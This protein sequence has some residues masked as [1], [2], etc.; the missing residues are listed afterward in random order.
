MKENGHQAPLAPQQGCPGS[1]KGPIQHP[2]HASRHRICHE[3][4]LSY[5]ANWRIKHVAKV[6]GASYSEALDCL[7]LEAYQWYKGSGPDVSR[8]LLK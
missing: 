1:S 3:V 2:F 4:H 6:W 8:L 7:L 5:A